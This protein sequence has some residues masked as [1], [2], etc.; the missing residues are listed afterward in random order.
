MDDI[1]PTTPFGRRPQTLGLMA[2]QALADNCPSDAIAHKWRCFRAI[3]EAKERLGV[4]D[5][6]LAVL[7]ALISFHR[8]T[9]LTAGSDLIVFP[10]NRELGLR[11]HGMA[12][13]T[14][15]RHL[16]ALVG[17]GLV[18]RRDSPNGK[19]YARR[20]GEG[21][22]QTAFGFD[23]A[24]LVSRAM[25]FERLAAEARA[26]RRA[27][28]RL[29]EQIT[30]LR[31]D[32]DK[33]IAA[34]VEADLDGPWRD[35]VAQLAGQ[36]ALPRAAHREALETVSAEL[37]TLRAAVD[38]SV[39]DALSRHGPSRSASEGQL[40]SSKMS[41]NESQTERHYQNSKTDPILESE[42]SFQKSAGGPSVSKPAPSEQPSRSYPLRMA[43]EACPDILTYAR[44]GISS[45]SDFVATAR[46]VRSSLGVSPDAWEQA[47]EA[48]GEAGASIAVAAILQRSGAIRSPGGYLRSLTEK[49]R[50]GEFSLGPVLMALLNTRLRSRGSPADSRSSHS[51]RRE[52]A[53]VVPPGKGRRRE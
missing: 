34:A 25:E 43:L 28:Q 20:D 31:R 12:P 1:R 44:H 38:K 23:L 8:E 46:V 16:S 4:S 24:P 15:R 2:A 32:I 52:A 35:Y 53:R 10:S 17:A 36:R 22:V 9:A 49:A 33:T 14:L 27:N 21:D 41:A 47:C 5:R 37:R 51:R 40:R 26:E 7:G 48:L 3:T 29:R 18:I 50:I 42:P 30:I 19:R 45:W 13:A 6:A 11:S 39:E